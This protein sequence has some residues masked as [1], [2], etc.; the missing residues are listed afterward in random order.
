[1]W[2][3]EVRTLCSSLKELQLHSGGTSALASLH[4]VMH[5]LHPFPTNCTLKAMK[6]E[7]CD[8]ELY[9]IHQTMT[10]LDL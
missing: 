10:E 2:V 8:T 7:Q 3:D 1:M 6:N 9:L 4:F 5:V